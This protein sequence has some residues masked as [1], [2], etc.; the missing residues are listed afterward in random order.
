MASALDLKFAY[1][2]LLEEDIAVDTYTDR[3]NEATDPLLKSKLIE[4]IKDENDHKH[5]FEEYLRNFKIKGP[6]S[7]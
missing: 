7:G 6:I 2:S 5:I 4:V 3:L 1:A